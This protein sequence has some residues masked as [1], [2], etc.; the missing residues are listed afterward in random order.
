MPIAAGSHFTARAAGA[1]EVTMAVPHLLRDHAF[2][3]GAHQLVP[4]KRFGQRPPA[5][6]EEALFGPVAPER[7]P[8]RAEREG[9]REREKSSA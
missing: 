7:E 5:G 3:G 8:A 2:P 6:I 9:T 4:G 1:R